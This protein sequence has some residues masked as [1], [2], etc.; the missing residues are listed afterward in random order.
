VVSP[1]AQLLWKLPDT[2]K[3]QVRIALSRTYKAPLTRLLVPRRYTTNNGNGP[4]NPDVRGNP[5]LRPELAWGL[6]AGY[7]KYFGKDGMASVSAYVR[8]IDDVIVYAVDPDV[9][10]WLSEP[11]NKGRA[12]AAGVEAD[13]KLSPRANLDLRA[14][15]GYNWSAID[16]TPGPDNR[17]VGQVRVTSNLG[18]DYRP[19]PAWTV[20]ANLNL[21][22]AGAER[23]SEQQHAYVGPLRNL[24]LYALWKISE[25]SKW[26]LSAS[27]A[28]QQDR[29]SSQSYLSA[30]GLSTRSFIE[31]NRIIVRLT[32]E[33][34]L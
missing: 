2:D 23:V 8:R 14:N 20:G 1:V 6:D 26:R 19:S 30:A 22:F 33:S 24:D 12:K 10:P 31:T 27:D 32:L 18:L 5:N 17:L 7:E 9:R 29:R 13:A 16:A 34:R 25:K 28:L 15:L 21:Q 3:D 4:T 11:F